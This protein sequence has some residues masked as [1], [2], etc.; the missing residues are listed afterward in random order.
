MPRT[1]WVFTFLVAFPMMATH[2]QESTHQHENRNCTQCTGQSNQHGSQ[3][4]DA[5]EQ[6]HHHCTCPSDCP[7]RT[8]GAECD[9]GCDCA[10]NCHHE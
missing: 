5:R 8:E 7:C 2:E 1:F 3:H 10:G 4:G 6:G 9:C